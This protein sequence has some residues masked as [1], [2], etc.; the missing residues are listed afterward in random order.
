MPVYILGDQ[1]QFSIPIVF[2]SAK[3]IQGLD[4][5]ISFNPDLVLLSYDIGNII[6]G[7]NIIGSTCI[8]F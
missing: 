4:I 7:L 1:D 5:C 8:Y 3:S 2:D 6:K